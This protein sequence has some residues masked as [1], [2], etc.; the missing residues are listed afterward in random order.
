MIIFVYNKISHK[1]IENIVNIVTGLQIRF[2]NTIY[3]KLQKKM[4]DLL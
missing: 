3:K 1:K 2:L 4:S